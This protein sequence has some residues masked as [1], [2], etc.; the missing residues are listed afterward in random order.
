MAYPSNSSF[1]DLRSKIRTPVSKTK[2]IL[3]ELEQLSAGTNKKK[4]IHELENSRWIGSSG[5]SPLP[6]RRSSF[7]PSRIQQI[8]AGLNKSALRNRNDALP[9]WRRSL[10]NKPRSAFEPAVDEDGDVEMNGAVASTPLGPPSSSKNAADS[11][12]A[13][14]TP[15]LKSVNRR[16]IVSNDKPNVFSLN[17]PEE[18]G[19]ADTSA[20]EKLVP[21][22]PGRQLTG[23]FLNGVRGPRPVVEPKAKETPAQTPKPSSDSESVISEVGSDSE[24]DNSTVPQKEVVPEVPKTAEAAKIPDSTSVSITLPLFSATTTATPAAAPAAPAAAPAAAAEKKWECDDCWPGTQ[25][26]PDE[27]AAPPAP[28]Q[29]FKPTNFAANLQS[30]PAPFQFGFGAAPASTAAPP[31]VA[32]LPE[33]PATNGKIPEPTPA[34]GPDRRLQL[35]RGVEFE[36]SDCTPDVSA[37]DQRPPRMPPDVTFTFG[38]GGGGGIGAPAAPAPSAAATA[39]AA[40]GMGRRKLLRET[41]ILKRTRRIRALVV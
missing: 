33:L 15:I 19:D 29:A 5:D 13:K 14:H 27:N 24:S 31:A 2:L 1:I 25:S 12:I 6:P 21:L 17:E 38:G 32:K 8:S 41:K 34:A 36:R 4:P 3:Q 9:Y 30:S 40:G 26:K 7:T 22:I 16:T 35:R 39:A 10:V 28:K 18:N 20:L 37:S 23:G 11:S